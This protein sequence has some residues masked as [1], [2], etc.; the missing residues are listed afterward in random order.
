MGGV[1]YSRS[2][3]LMLEQS[4]NIFFLEKNTEVTRKVT[5]TQYKFQ[6]MDQQC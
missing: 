3:K 2:M 4:K 6:G 1:F 5:E